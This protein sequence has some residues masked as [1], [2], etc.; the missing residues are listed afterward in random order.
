M[1]APPAPISTYAPYDDSLSYTLQREQTQSAQA[2]PH[3]SNDQL[4]PQSHSSA[5]SEPAYQ[6]QAYSET[7]SAPLPRIQGAG[8][9]QGTQGEDFSVILTSATDLTTDSR[10]LYKIMFGSKRCPVTIHK[11]I[12][13]QGYPQYA[14]M[15]KVPPISS[16]GW[17]SNKVTVYLNMEDEQGQELSTEEVNQYTY[18]NVSPPQSY[19][20]SPPLPLK[21]R[22][23][24]E[25]EAQFDD[26][27]VKRQQ[28]LLQSDIKPKAEDY[29]AYSYPSVGVPSYPSSYAP[30]SSDDRQAPYYDQPT[31]VRQV[32]LTYKQRVPSLPQ[33]P[34]NLDIGSELP[35]YPQ[36]TNVQ[37]WTGGMYLNTPQ[38]IHTLPATSQPQSQPN[39][40]LTSLPSPLDTPNPPLVRTS[41]LQQSAYVNPAAQPGGSFN[42]YAVY[43]HKAVLKLQGNLDAMAEQWNEEEW[44]NKRRLVQFWRQQKGSA[45]HT[46]FA[47]VGQSDRQSNSI[48]ISCIWW[49]EKNAAYV[50]SVDCIYLLESLIAVRFTVE[51]KNRIRRNLEGFHPLTVSKAKP[52]SENFFKLIMG[53]PNPKP[54]NIEKDVKVFPWKILSLA[55]KKIIGK[56]VSCYF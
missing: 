33:S 1:L 8:P 5:M 50:T 19:T 45:I 22:K 44:Q 37:P 42:P 32:N 18:T 30:A 3:G 31:S 16:T 9:A 23:A 26:R 36:T 14:L 25:D 53:F 24:V 2:S 41:T 46:S 40:V 27:D 51:E 6:T 54:R 38:P 12:D 11:Q 13:T 15:T 29:V 7:V 10:I 39:R 43:P 35:R 48:C 34:F 28:P 55:L 49:A 52:D 21:K 20:T 17:Y 56:Y 47:P 4:H